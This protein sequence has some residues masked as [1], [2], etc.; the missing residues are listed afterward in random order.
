VV[1]KIKKLF[2]RIVDFFAKH[3]KKIFIGIACLLLV[4]ILV[5]VFWPKNYSLPFSRVGS[6]KIGV[7]D[8]GQVQEILEN[9]FSE[10]KIII[11]TN[12]NSEASFKGESILNNGTINE[13]WRHF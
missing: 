7:I 4:V 9:Q 13:S 2:R 11:E 8:R 3:R 5:Q 12:V 6:E 10:S 1:Q